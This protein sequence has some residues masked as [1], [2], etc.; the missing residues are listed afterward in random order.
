MGT[1]AQREYRDCKVNQGRLGRT[2][3]LAGCTLLLCLIFVFLPGSGALAAST[4]PNVLFTIPTAGDTLVGLNKS[5]AAVFDRDLDE[6]SINTQTFVLQT[7]AGVPVSAQTVYYDPATRTAV[8]TP[9]APLLADTEYRAVLTTGIKDSTGHALAEDYAWSFSTG[10]LPF[11]NPHGNYLSNTAACK[12]CHQTHTAQGKALLKEGM[13]TAVCYTCHDGSG[14]RFDIERIFS[15]TGAT[16]TY[17]PVM[18]T[19]NPAVNG[20]MQCTDCHNP[21]GDKDEFGNVYPRLLDAND[22]TTANHQG[23]AFCLSCHGP[24]DLNLT[25]D[26]YENTLGDHTNNLAA[27]YDTSKSLLL[28]SSGTEVTCV[29]CHDQHSGSY[30]DLLNQGEENACLACH[31]NAANSLSG[32]N[33]AEEFAKTG[34]HHDITSDSGAKVECSSCHGPHAVGEAKLSDNLP[35]S[36]LSDPSNTK[37]V[38]TQVPGT[39][40]ATVGDRTD[41]CLICHSGSPPAAQ[42]STTSLVPFSIVFPSVNFTTN[43]GNGGNGWDKSTYKTSVHYV[44]GMGC[45]V[46]HLPHGSDYPRLQLNPEDTDTVNGECLS[47]H[48]GNPPPEYASAPNLKT[49]LTQ[50]GDGTTSPDRYR[51]PTLYIS[52]VHTDTENY[53]T[54]KVN[55]DRHAECLD[56]HDPHNEQEATGINAPPL[57]PAPL[58]NVTGVDVDYSGITWD[59]WDTTKNW[60]FKKPIV[61]QYQLCYKCHSSYAWQTSPPTFAGSIQETD[62]PR[63][64]NPNNASYHAVVGESKIPTFVYN[65]LSYYYG[66]FTSNLDSSGQ[67]WSATSRMFCEDCH[68]SGV[69]GLRGP[70]GSNYWYLLNGPWTPSGGAE[71]QVGTGT[72]GTSDHLCFDCHTYDFYGRGALPGSYT[73]RSQFSSR[74]SYNLHARHKERGCST[75]HVV[76]PHGYFRQGLLAI[77][78]DPEPYNTGAWLEVINWREPGAWAKSDCNHG[79]I[80]YGPN[81]GLSCG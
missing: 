74:N 11:Y 79:V 67:P 63:E 24:T 52:G 6:T 15:Q 58:R 37:K 73:L 62:I 36:D 29:T 71:G 51:H 2:V 31:D 25:L 55:G 35:Y 12:S 18:D 10:T 57:A 76:V 61:Y 22:G 53:S 50:L 68:S 72:P 77:T 28:P 45:E 4:I 38:F 14:S 78:S 43:N 7:A 60:I 41:F 27:H 81:K 13:Q 44:K 9:A 3:F 46:C 20:V 65:N 42:H 32:I 33:V 1:V 80:Q 70:H 16:R 48:G 56:C 5:L 75:C 26:Y 34:S 66:S 59:N 47:C 21:H 19:G 69:S 39:P 30:A 64:F 8:F 54:L 49:D 17:H 40:N 23:N